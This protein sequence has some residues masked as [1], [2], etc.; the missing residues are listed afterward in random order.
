MDIVESIQQDNFNLLEWKHFI[1]EG[2]LILYQLAVVHINRLCVCMT[3]HTYTY[4]QVICFS[5]WNFK[6]KALCFA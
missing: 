6:V 1:L 2:T 5:Q 3:E 4:L